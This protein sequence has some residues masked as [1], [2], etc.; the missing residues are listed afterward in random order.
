MNSGFPIIMIFNDKYSYL[1]NIYIYSLNKYNSDMNIRLIILSLIGDGI[2]TDSKNKIDHILKDSKITV[3]YH[4]FELEYEY[5][6]KEGGKCGDN[7]LDKIVYLRLE[8]QNHFDFEKCL[9]IDGDMICTQNIQR[10]INED[11]ENYPIGGWYDPD[12]NSKNIKS[13]DNYKHPVKGYFNAGCLLLNLT[14]I[15]DYTKDILLHN[16]RFAD[17]DI[18]NI[19]FENNWKPIEYLSYMLKYNHEQHYRDPNND[20]YLKDL[21]SQET[22]EQPC[23]LFLHTFPKDFDNSVYKH[24]IQEIYDE[25]DKMF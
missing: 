18:L 13:H 8:L 21:P 3:E 5:Y 23:V 17:Q 2:S 22:D 16:Y 14:K 15:T 20:A 11:L 19:V 10:I 12:M 4:E 6:L 7:Y 24:F 25:V 1:S 9:Y